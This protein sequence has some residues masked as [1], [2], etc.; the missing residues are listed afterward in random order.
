MHA[1]GKGKLQSIRI[2]AEV[3]DPAQ[4]TSNVESGDQQVHAK[5]TVGMP[6]DVYDDLLM[7]FQELEST[8]SFST[9][10]ALKRFDW[11]APTQ[12]FIP[13]T[14]GEA[15]QV[16]VRDFKMKSAYPIS[17]AQLTK[18]DMRDILSH[19][20]RYMSLVIPKSFYREGLNEYN[21]FRYINAFH[22]FYYVLEGLY[23]GI[24]K[25]C[26]NSQA[27]YPFSEQHGLEAQERR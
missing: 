5:I 17:K 1:D 20:H 21:D 8:L 19:K 14:E 9:D 24:L 4:V 3:P 26:V 18:D 15:A 25:K 13:E 2:I 12:D 27:V 10:G 16:S 23:G 11:N 7:E 22:N 6:L